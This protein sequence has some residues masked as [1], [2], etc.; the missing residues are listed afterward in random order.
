MRLIIRTIFLLIFC[1]FIAN[2]F[3]IKD[4]ISGIEYLDDGKFHSD[5]SLLESSINQTTYFIIAAETHLSANTGAS[6]VINAYTDMRAVS[7]ECPIYLVL[8]N[9]GGVQK[10][11]LE[12]YV[13]EVYRI[14]MD[15]DKNFYLVHNDS[16]YRY[17]QF[18]GVLSKMYYIHNGM[19]AYKNNAKHH[20]IVDEK[21]PRHKFSL[22]TESEVRLNSGKVRL[23]FMDFFKPINE[24][25]I[26]YLSDIQNILLTF[27]TKTGEIINTYK[28]D[29]SGI[30]HY[31][32]LI[33]KTENECDIAKKHVKITDKL[34]RKSYYIFNFTSDG[35]HV[36]LSAG[37]QVF[38][39]LPEDKVIINDENKEVVYK[40]GDMFAYGYSTLGVLDT[41]LKPIKHYYLPENIGP[42][43]DITPA[44]D[45][46]LASIGNKIITPAGH[47]KDAYSESF[48]PL[49]MQLAIDDSGCK[50]EKYLA[51]EMTEHYKKSV[52]AN[53]FDHFCSFN[54]TTL[55]IADIEHLLYDINQKSPVSYLTGDGRPMVKEDIPEFTEESD[56]Y[57]L[58]FITASIGSD[59]NY[60]YIVYRYQ[61]KY[62]LEIKDSAYKTL[63]VIDISNWGGLS[64]LP[65]DDRG[66]SIKI[67]NN[68]I[69]ITH[70]KNDDYY[71]SVYSINTI[72]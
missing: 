17:L 71:L 2:A 44:V 15:K 24:N 3:T 47:F 36:Y 12:W 43:K 14:P 46:G 9:N 13:K 27:D 50:F 52:L 53:V 49:L 26:L 38:I 64:K 31:C 66:E 35:Q 16:L 22:K 5:I 1:P 4:P 61:G 70:M 40:K 59:G 34:N 37:L 58:N 19:L 42:D 21:L 62:L 48:K 55:F 6:A 25:K 29:K 57:I 20:F 69:F 65:K 39:R 10:K 63:D 23:S 45:F 54:G 72:K 30:D 41:N 68:K 51:P 8:N 33:A 32:E 18:G 56:E 11:D 60:L 7:Q 67:H 28:Q